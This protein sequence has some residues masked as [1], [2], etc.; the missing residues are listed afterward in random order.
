MKRGLNKGARPERR[1]AYGVAAVAA[2]VV[3][4]VA[5]FG[6]RA[7]EYADDAAGGDAGTIELEVALRCDGWSPENSELGVFVSGAQLDGSPCDEQLVFEGAGVRTAYLGAGSYEIVPQ[8]PMLMLRDGAVLAASDPAARSYGEGAPKSDAL[9]VV[10]R[11]IDARDMAE[12]ELR[13]VAEASFVLE[14]DANA[15][16]ERALARQSEEAAHAEA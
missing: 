11:A 10:Y 16:F 6:W 1:I 13:A 14:D 15:A 7:C 4:S 5:F 8:L 2:V 3:A 12:G 9:E